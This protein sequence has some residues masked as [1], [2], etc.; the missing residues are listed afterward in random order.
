MNAEVVKQALMSYYLF[1]RQFL[2]VTTEQVTTYG[3]ADVWVMDKDYLALEIEVKVSRSDLLSELN[4]IRD[5]KFFNKPTTPSKQ[6]KKYRKHYRYLTKY[7]Q[8]DNVALLPN[9]FYYCVPIEL[10]SIALEYLKD[11]PYGILVCE[12][13]EIGGYEDNPIRTVQNIQVIKSGKC[14]H[15][16]EVSQ[17]IIKQTL[18][19]ICSENYN[20]R[21]KWKK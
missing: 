6:L 18:R 9:R 19:R 21:V 4:S 2:L 7:H 3:T 8:Y 5:I 17:N 20:L 1:E 11:T 10:A 14:L 13:R 12:E 16:G 15:N